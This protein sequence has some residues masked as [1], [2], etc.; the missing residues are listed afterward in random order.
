MN[1]KLTGLILVV[2]ALF[3]VVVGFD[4][5]VSQNR[6]FKRFSTQDPPSALKWINQEE[7]QQQKTVF[8]PRIQMGSS[9]AEQRYTAALDDLR[10]RQMN[11]N[12]RQYEKQ[13]V[14]Q[15]MKT[16][17]GEHLIKG[18][19]FLRTGD[20]KS[21]REYISTALGMHHE[22]DFAEYVMMLKGLL[23]TYVDKQD[24]EDLDKAVLRY[25]QLIQGQYTQTGFQR[26]IN[27]LMDALKEKIINE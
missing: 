17:A 10:E 5:F 9:V 3:F 20:Q 12:Q 23:H 16:A 8:G 13:K 6:S 14:R 22:Y 4:L 1:V 21:A 19:D 25:L 24:R 27:E 15:F 18:L 11:R 7:A 2:T 26:A